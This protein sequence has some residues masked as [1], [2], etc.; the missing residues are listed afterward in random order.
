MKRILLGTTTL[1]G[2]AG[3]LAGA[4]FAETPKVTLGGNADFQMGYGSGNDIKQNDVRNSAFKSDTEVTVR[5]DGKT[6]GGLGYGGG[7]DLEA[8]TTADADQ[9][10]TVTNASR[11]FIYL[12][13][14][15]WGRI[16]AGS[17]YGVTNTMKV[18]AA[19]IARAT[20]GIDGDFTYFM[21]VHATPAQNN[22]VIATPD[23][24]LDY[25]FDGTTAS[26]NPILGDETTETANKI[27]Y[28][29]PRFMGAQ[30]G[31]SYLIDNDNRG[32]TIGVSKTTTTGEAHNIITAGATWEGTFSNVGIKLGATM[33]RGDAQDST[34][35]DLR[36]WQAGAKLSYMGFSVAGSYGDWGDSVRLTSLGNVEAD[37]FTLG[38]AYEAGPI[39]VSVTYLDSTYEGSST[40]ENEFSNLSVGADYKLAPGF[41]PYAEVSFV[42]MDVAST[43]GADNETAVFI[44]GSSLAF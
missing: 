5:V 26:S 29:T 2:A 33:E 21:D 20:G 35:E 6:D 28:Y 36:S 17:D 18:D 9:N 44:V 37:F 13:G 11:T 25:G 19:S 24:I 22:R 38:A 41:T 23:L 12:E 15:S 42:E 27:S 3:L 32:Q 40:T 30:L 34:Y 43:S 14:N 31:V 7:I 1:I 8:D 16:Q 10:S 39:G 4:A